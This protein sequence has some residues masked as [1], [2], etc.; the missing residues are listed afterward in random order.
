M[1]LKYFVEAGAIACRR[2]P[3]DD[4]KWVAAARAGSCRGLG[5][6]LGRAAALAGPPAWGA[7]A[8]QQGSRAAA[9]SR[10]RSSRRA[11]CLCRRIAK[12][13]GAS[14]VLTL[15]DMEGNETFEASALGSCEEVAEERVSDD[16]MLVLRGCRWV[17]GWLAGWGWWWGLQGGGWC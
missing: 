8:L 12:A 3:K 7:G 13:T 4:L 10:R 11:A 16:N 9:A 1:A 15:A 2:V 14:V 6:C 5:C 17:A